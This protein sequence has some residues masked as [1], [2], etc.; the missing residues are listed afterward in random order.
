MAEPLG[1]M[2]CPR[3]GSSNALTSTQC[4][5]C[6]SPLANAPFDHAPTVGP[7]SDT[8]SPTTTRSGDGDVTRF[9]DVITPSPGLPST[10][11]RGGHVAGRYDIVRLLGV[12]GMGAVYQAW[13]EKLG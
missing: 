13:D 2:P 1:E 6:G 8:T 5:V 10:F 11:V 7:P 4:L 3:C 12:G 9:A